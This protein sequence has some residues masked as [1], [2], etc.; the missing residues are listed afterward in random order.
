MPTIKMVLRLAAKSSF[1]MLGCFQEVPE[2]HRI[3]WRVASMG[4]HIDTV[5]ILN[6]NAV[7]YDA[8]VL[9]TET[10]L[11]VVPCLLP[12]KKSCQISQLNH[13]AKLRARESHA[14]L[15][16]LDG[17]HHHVCLH[18]RIR[19]VKQTTRIQLSVGVHSGRFAGI[20]HYMSSKRGGIVLGST[21][22]YFIA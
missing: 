18:F 10:P 2:V 14:P 12:A 8:S 4:F 20:V 6:D 13:Q 1:A 11:Y 22:G 5:Q 21:N 17:V 19:E 16:A 3:Y 9:F 7:R 15:A